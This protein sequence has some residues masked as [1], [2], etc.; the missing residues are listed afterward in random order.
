MESNENKSKKLGKNDASGFE[1][2]KRVLGDNET[3]A[4]NF[5]R[6]QKHPEQG[7]IIFELLK[8]GEEQ[9]VT[10]YTSHPRNYWNKNSSKFLSLWRACQDL[11]ATLY[12]VNYADINT[13]YADQ[14]LL[15]EVKDMDENGITDEIDTRYTIDE[16]SKWFIKLNNECL[17]SK[18][19]IIQD[20]YNGKSLDELGKIK[21]RKGKY[22]NKCI[23]D[24]YA[25]D[26]AYLEWHSKSDYEYSRAVKSYLNKIKQI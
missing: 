10:P 13:R 9:S 6:F 16:F 26:G 23:S 25:Q 22:A 20:I 21:L 2:V 5:D 3:A 17:E 12:L 11:H 19:S 14:V 15:I 8:C 7:Y 24:I 18:N 4:V 1:F